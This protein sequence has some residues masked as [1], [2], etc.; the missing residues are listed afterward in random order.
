MTTQVN[1]RFSDEGVERQAAGYRVQAAAPKT[2]TPGYGPDTDYRPRPD[3]IGQ[4]DTV[5]G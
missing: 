5:I 2:C 1:R 3:A 4:Q